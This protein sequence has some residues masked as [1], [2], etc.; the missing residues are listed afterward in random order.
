ME[1]IEVIL[2]DNIKRQLKLY[3]SEL[4][5]FAPFGCAIYS[6]NQVA[7]LSAYV[8]DFTN[9]NKLISLLENNIAYKL[10]SYD[11]LV[12]AIAINIIVTEN[13]E[14]YDAIELRVYKKDKKTRIERIN[15]TIE[16]DKVHLH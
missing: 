5:E 15:Y 13:D 1:T 7:P 9:S 8:G 12:A 2:V 10:N 11:Y 6:N 3:L 14:K 16:K 4:G